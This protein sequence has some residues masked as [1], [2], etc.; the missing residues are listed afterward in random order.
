[1]VNFSD[2]FAWAVGQDGGLA[3][4]TPLKLGIRTEG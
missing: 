2:Q 3:A 1:M 4:G